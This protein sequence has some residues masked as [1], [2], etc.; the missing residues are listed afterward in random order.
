MRKIL[1]AIGVIVGLASGLRAQDADVSDVISRQIEAFR[2]DDFATAFTYA[3]PS[4]RN[5][6]G[7]PENFGR[8]VV[9][10]YPMVW[11]PAEVD[12][13][14]TQRGDGTARQIVRIED[15]AGRV[16]Y[17]GYDMIQTETGWKIAG[18]QILRADPAAS[19]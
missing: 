9:Q 11:R 16:F 4:I 18:V 8:M 5:L 2:A 13:E 17:L 1:L 3:S 19:A 6:F 12:F 7:T 14:Q 15:A 10:G